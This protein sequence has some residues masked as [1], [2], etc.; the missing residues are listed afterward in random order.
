MPP[1]LVPAKVE[2]PAYSDDESI[3]RADLTY[4]SVADLAHVGH[5]LRPPTFQ[6]I[7]TLSPHLQS[8]AEVADLP[9]LGLQFLATYPDAP[10][11]PLLRCQLLLQ[12]W[13]GGVGVEHSAR[14]LIGASRALQLLVLLGRQLVREG[15]LF[16]QT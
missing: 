1:A 6:H 2:H 3:L 7:P 9:H 10:H 14:L 5:H 12:L 13:I 15:K 8:P 4:F 16:Q 11:L